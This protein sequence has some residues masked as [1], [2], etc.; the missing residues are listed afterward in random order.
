MPTTS[1]VGREAINE[2]LLAA[3][4]EV[5]GFDREELQPDTSL[6]EIEL[7]SLL[8]V[9]LV[10]AVRRRFGVELPPTEFRT[11]IENVSELCTV[12]GDFIDQHLRAG[13]P[14]AG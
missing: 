9:E 8:I 1:I 14:S 11:E 10:I 3:I 6:V 2:E 5:T 12:L 4:A 13:A 7:D